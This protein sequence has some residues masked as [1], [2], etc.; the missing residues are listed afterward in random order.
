M[1]AAIVQQLVESMVMP[2]IRNGNAE[3]FIEDIQPHFH[4]NATDKDGNRLW[5]PANVPDFDPYIS[6]RL[7]PSNEKPLEL[8]SAKSNNLI[9]ACSPDEAKAMLEKF[10]TIILLK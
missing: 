2:N 9:Y 6:I 5:P 3:K 7:C 10:I 8:R 1:N 4:I